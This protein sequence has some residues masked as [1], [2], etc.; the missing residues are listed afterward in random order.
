MKVSNSV[1][2]LGMLSCMQV[3]GQ[4]TPLL[5]QRVRRLAETRVKEGAYPSLVHGLEKFLAGYKAMQA[6]G[7][8]YEYSNLGFG[9]LGQALAASSRSSYEALLRQRVTEP[10]G[11][12]ATAITLTPLLSERF[13]APHNPAGKPT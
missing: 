4:P 7:E 11:M 10:L 3:F 12:N 1:A 9:L 13:A 5:D 8:H 6:P 2:I